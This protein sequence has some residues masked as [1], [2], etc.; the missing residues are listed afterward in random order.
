MR[1]RHVV[2][3]VQVVVRE[4]L[5][6]T[7]EAVLPPRDET[8]RLRV[9]GPRRGYLRGDARSHPRLRR[10]LLFLLRR[11][12]QAEH[13]ERSP[14]RDPYGLQ[15]VIGDDKVLHPANLGRLDERALEVVGP[16]VVRAREALRRGCRTVPPVRIAES[17]AGVR[18]TRVR[19]C[20]RNVAGRGRDLHPVVPARVVKRAQDAIL[21]P[22]H[23]VLDRTGGTHEVGPVRRHLVDAAGPGPTPREDPFALQRRDREG[24]DVPRRGGRGGRGDAGGRGGP[25]FDSRANRGGDA[26]RFLIGSAPAADDSRRVGIRLRLP[27]LGRR[28][29]ETDVALEERTLLPARHDGVRGAR[30]AVDRLFRL[31]PA[32]FD[33]FLRPFRRDCGAFG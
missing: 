18:I 5:P 6:V 23:D 26:S 14:L 31:F 33:R 15:A 32:V 22:H 19:T 4:H 7:P 12:T 9:V 17:V 11:V 2:A 20:T 29:A 8:H 1:E 16:A 28:V 25:R 13:H 3:A 27:N 21:A 10:L 24:V 30:A